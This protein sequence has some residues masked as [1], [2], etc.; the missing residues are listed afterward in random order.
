M[1]SLSAMDLEPLHS[2]R[3]TVAFSSH[4]PETLPYVAAWMRRH[5]IVALEEPPNEL[6][7]V[8]RSMPTRQARA[9]VVARYPAR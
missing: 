3:V 1:R 7:E 8:T 4:R 2:S 9:E 5:D 6:F